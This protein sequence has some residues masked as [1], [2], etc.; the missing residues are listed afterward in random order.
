PTR[1]G[2][3]QLKIGQIKVDVMFKRTKNHKI[4]WTIFQAEGSGYKAYYKATPKYELTDENLQF[5][6]FRFR[7][8]ANVDRYLSVRYGNWRQP[9]S[10]KDWSCY[11]SDG[12]LVSSFE[13]I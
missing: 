3:L 7:T 9:V 6:G 12:A 8:I 10:Y 1:T 11:T 4:W 2:Q 5:V 13:A